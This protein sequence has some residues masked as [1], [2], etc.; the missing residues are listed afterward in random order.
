[1]LIESTLQST[2]NFV[3]YMNNEIHENW[4]S[5]I[6]DEITVKVVLT[7]YIVST[8]PFPFTFMIS[9]SDLN[10]LHFTRHVSCFDFFVSQI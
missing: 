6:M 9:V 10:C 4:Y 8:H 5:M 2:F 3:D 1:M 7:V